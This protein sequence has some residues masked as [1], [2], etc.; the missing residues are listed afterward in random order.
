M[1]REAAQEGQRI[2]D[3]IESIKHYMSRYRPYLHEQTE[4]TVTAKKNDNEDKFYLRSDS[5]LFLAIYSSLEDMVKELEDKLAK[6][7]AN[8]K[9]EYHTPPIRR[10]SFWKKVWGK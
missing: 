7:D 4:L 8:D 5:P 10:T 6:L 9:T 2:I 1:T 3:Q